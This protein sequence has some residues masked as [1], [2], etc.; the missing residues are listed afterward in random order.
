MGKIL[1]RPFST[2]GLGYTDY[3]EILNYYVITWISISNLNHIDQGTCTA[4]ADFCYCL[5]LMST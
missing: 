3:H 5:L 4:C 1:V 2:V